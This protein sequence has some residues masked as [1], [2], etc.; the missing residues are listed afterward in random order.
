MG[1]GLVSRTFLAVG[2]AALLLMSGCS[3]DSEDPTTNPSNGPTSTPAAAG[4]APPTHTVLGAGLTLPED[5]Q[6]EES[7]V[8]R[9]NSDESVFAARDEAG[10][11][12]CGA[13]LAVLS[14]PEMEPAALRDFYEGM[15]GEDLV[16]M[17]EGEGPDGV[18]EEIA[19]RVEMDRNPGADPDVLVAKSWFSEGGSVAVA[20]ARTEPG[21][22]TGCDPEAIVSTLVWDGAQRPLGE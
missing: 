18:S 20:S 22:P 2:A 16:W 5:L 9:D 10:N 7:S 19:I 1:D 12:A 4:A 11:W 6:W 8:T 14:E 17:E 13:R 3:G 15:H 21:N